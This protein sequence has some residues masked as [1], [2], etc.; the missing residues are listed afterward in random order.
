MNGNVNEEIENLKD[1]SP[2]KNP[3]T[4][5]CNNWNEKFTSGFQ[6]QTWAVIR[7]NQQTWR[8]DSGNYQWGTGRR[9]TNGGCSTAKAPSM[10]LVGDPGEE[11]RNRDREIT[12]LM[13]KN[14]LNLMKHMKIHI[15]KINKLQAGK[16]QRPTPR[17]FSPTAE[18]QR[19]RERMPKAAREKPTATSK[20]SSAGASAEL[21]AGTLEDK[22]RGLAYS[23]C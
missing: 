11:K 23:K 14:L 18:S 10:L 7:Q 21:S 19:Q 6:R 4:K 5:N 22:R 17:H 3:G 16:I 1:P 8:Q 13:V 20:E 2:L 12:W 9:R 15:Q